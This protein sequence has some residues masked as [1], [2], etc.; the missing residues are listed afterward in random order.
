MASR[1]PRSKQAAPS[2]PFNQNGFFVAETDPSPLE[3]V[4]YKPPE[5]PSPNEPPLSFQPPHTS[6]PR[7]ASS[8]RPHHS[9]SHHPS[10]TDDL[11]EHSSLPP[12]KIPRISS[13][14]SRARNPP[15]PTVFG[16]GS[17]TSPSSDGTFLQTPVTRSNSPSQNESHSSNYLGSRFQE[18]S[19]QAEVEADAISTSL[20]DQGRA[21]DNG[22]ST[23]E[24]GQKSY[25]W[26]DEYVE[27]VR[28][29]PYGPAPDDMTREIMEQ[30]VDIPTPSGSRNAV[31]EPT[32]LSHPYIMS[33]TALS[34]PT[35]DGVQVDSHPQTSEEGLILEADEEFNAPF[36]HERAVAGRFGRLVPV[37]VAPPSGHITSSSFDSARPSQSRLQEEPPSYDEI[38]L[39]PLLD[40]GAEAIVGPGFITIS[41]P[42]AK[43][44]ANPH[45]HVGSHSLDDSSTSSHPS[46]HPS[47]SSMPRSHSKHHPEASVSALAKE[48]A[49][50]PTRRMVDRGSRVTGSFEPTTPMD[51]PNP[52]LTAQSPPNNPS[53]KQPRSGSEASDGTSSSSS[54]TEPDPWTRDD[55]ENLERCFVAERN[56]VAK[57]SGLTSSRDVGLDEI[58]VDL[59][60]ERFKALLVA[61]K[62]IKVGSDWD[63]TKLV[64]RVKSLLDRASKESS[65][66]GSPFGDRDS[67]TP[68]VSGDNTDDDP[69]ASTGTPHQSAAVLPALDV[70]GIRSSPQL[71]AGEVSISTPEQSVFSPSADGVSEPGTPKFIVTSEV[72]D[73][74]NRGEGYQTTPPPTSETAFKQPRPRVSLVVKSFEDSTPP[75]QASGPHPPHTPR[76]LNTHHTIQTRQALRAPLAPRAPRTPHTAYAP[77]PLEVAQVRRGSPTSFGS[78]LRK[79]HLGPRKSNEVRL[80]REREVRPLLRH[81]ESSIAPLDSAPSPA[82]GISIPPLNHVKTSMRSPYSP[83][84]ASHRARRVSSG[85]SVGDLVRGWEQVNQEEQRR[86]SISSGWISTPSPA[87]DARRSRWSIAGPAPS[88]AL[89]R[90]SELVVDAC[91]NPET[92]IFSEN[93]PLPGETLP[94]SAHQAREI[95]EPEREAVSYGA[96][97]HKKFMSFLGQWAPF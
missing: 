87:P 56:A 59:V 2:A 41:S 76:S 12:R 8:K 95:V 5:L 17:N 47:S 15:S 79:P 13:D 77:H 3:F 43:V 72:L 29:P 27:R 31:S 63:R 39:K 69:I 32:S 58:E 81:R 85:G 62:Q 20:Q 11:H 45:L 74:L 78:P 44:A 36:E 93:L 94:R 82:R 28:G 6:T 97:F 25:S 9:S 91:V 92:S 54:N 26:L 14:L 83:S 37:V 61:S 34:Q 88:P 89:R 48:E 86:A 10:P 75:L 33:S 53:G 67:V 52:I 4:F 73:P 1:R 66:L 23:T 64:A 35:L 57:Q 55:W 50:E 21:L 40:E 65:D 49:E 60:V 70:A 90:S 46:V 19:A 18:P 51:A 24:G 68:S 30:F 42:D 71:N 7:R 96:A 84:E 38:D 16:Y 80:M 22:S